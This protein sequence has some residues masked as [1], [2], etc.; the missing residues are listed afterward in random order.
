MEVERVKQEVV[1]EPAPP[2]NIADR[3]SFLSMVRKH[4]GDAGVNIV[5]GALDMAEGKAKGS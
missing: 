4:M 5:K 1:Q 3:E 2:I